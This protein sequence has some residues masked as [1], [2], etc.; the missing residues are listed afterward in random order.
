[1]YDCYVWIILNDMN[2]LSCYVVVD[3]ILIMKE[4]ELLL[5]NIEYDLL[6]LNIYYMII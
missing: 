2:V 1:M 3:Y 4:C 6:Y 5:E